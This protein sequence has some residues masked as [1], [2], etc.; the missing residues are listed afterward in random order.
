MIKKIYI[1]IIW[2][3]TVTATTFAQETL[4]HTESTKPYQEAL[5]LINQGS[6]N[7]AYKWLDDFIIN[8]PL[9]DKGSSTI[10]LSEAKYYKAVAAKFAQDPSAEYQLSK[11]IE[12]NAGSGKVSAAYYHL[13]TLSFDKGEYQKALDAFKNVNANYLNADEYSQY[14]FQFPFTQFTLKDFKNAR[15]G[16]NALMKDS[17]NVHYRDA[18]YYS[19]LS[20][21]YLKD[22]KNALSTFQKIEQVTKYKNVVP[23]YI[24]SIYAI[25]KKY[26]KVI[27][28][29]EPKIPQLAKYDLE[30][31]HLV[32]NAYYELKDYPNA[33]KHLESYISKSSKVN[34]EDYYQLGFV[35]FQNKNYK[36]AIENFNKLTFLENP[37]VQNAMFLLGQAYEK[38]GDKQNA[39]NAFLQASR[40]K[41]DTNTQEESY[42]AYCKLSYELGMTNDAL[43]SLKKFISTYPNSKHLDEANEILADVYLNT[44]NYEEALSSIEKMPNKSTKIQSAYQKM[45]FYRGVE[46]YNDK[47]T[48]EAE[49]YFDKSLKYN[50]DKGIEAQAYYWKAELAHQ[51]NDFDVS[52]QLLNKYLALASNSSVSGQLNLGTAYYLQGYNGYKK[53]DYVSG[54]LAFEKAVSNLYKNEDFNIKQTIYPDAILRL[55]DCNLML[56]KYYDAKANYDIIIKNGYKGGDYALFQKGIIEGVSGNTNEKIANL[57][58]LYT[59]YPNSSYADEAIY[60]LGNTFSNQGKNIEAQEQYKNLIAKYPKSNLYAAAH[61]RLGLLYSNLDNDAEALKYYTIVLDKF[62]KTTEA[63]EALVAIK[64]IYIAQGNPNGYIK[65]AQKYQGAAITAS[66]QD[67]LI[68]LSAEAQFSKGE[69]VKAL[70]GLNEYLMQFPS[71]YFSL[72]AHFYRGECYFIQNADNDAKMDYEYILAQPDNKY[73]ERSALRSAA[74]NYKLKNYEKANK[75]YKKLLDLA[76]IDDNKREASMGIM[77]TAYKTQQYSEALQYAGKVLETP[78]LPESYTTEAIFYRGASNFELKNYESSIKDLENTIKKIKSEPAAEAK[79]KLTQYQYIKKNYKEAEKLAFEFIE[80]YPSYQIWL[81]KTYLLLSDVYYDQGN[82][83]QAKA[84]LQSIMDNY[85]QEDQYMQL[86]REKY[87]KIV[88]QEKN[89]SKVPTPSDSKVLEFDNK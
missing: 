42:F 5:E 70:N 60:E 46:L 24:T 43:I 50:I 71:G 77:R 14:Q 44:Q 9:T 21:Y 39:R 84:T 28:Y 51:R 7:L 68:Y 11:F 79:F 20:S 8:Y 81:V 3:L 83:F 6:Y 10:Y 53:K 59:Q 41:Y 63:N 56:K 19:G 69:Y 57:K 85:E 18:A 55:A 73:S 61:N 40:M 62:P 2:I 88:A 15:V 33:S 76:S 25:D 89:A 23:Y 65:L 38:I 78:Q 75:Y 86:A 29:G 1:A 30:M 72:Q 87:N 16:F 12:E 82:L 32:G 48:K 4:R 58:V 52:T 54:Q 36:G 17:T 67:S 26:D 13:G 47:K 35:H 31:H 27:S 74:I 45:A 64:E 49:Q 66:A 80:T 37:I 34:Q 22:Y